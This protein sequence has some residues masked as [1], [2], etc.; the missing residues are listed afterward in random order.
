MMHTKTFRSALFVPLTLSILLA[1]PRAGIPQVAESGGGGGFMLE[2]HKMDL[3]SLNSEMGARGFERFEEGLFWT[4]GS[5]YAVI[6]DRLVIGGSGAGATQAVQS[7]LYKAT[8]ALGYG[9]FNV[10]YI[11]FSR[12]NLRVFPTFGFGGQGVNLS[13]TARETAPS[14]EEILDD[15]R[16]EVGVSRGGFLCDLGLGADL[17]LPLGGDE[18]GRGG[19]LIGLRGGYTLS[20]FRSDWKMG[21]LDVV[22]GPDLE[23]SGPYI[24]MLI[25]GMGMGKSK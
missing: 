18:S 25:G 14:F 24:R 16:R 15:P 22:G 3:G 11:V 12:G 23:L 7:S 19:L 2:F 21:D 4:G 20:L 9:M 5:G 6:N 10:G 13:I 1:C 8:L 17:F